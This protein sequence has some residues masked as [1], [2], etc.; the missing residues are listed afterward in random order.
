M[1]VGKCYNNYMTEKEKFIIN[2][3]TTFLAAKAAQEYTYCCMT[4]NHV[5]LVETAPI[6]DAFFIANEI[7]QN[8]TFKEE[9]KKLLNGL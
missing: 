6:E 7:W 4:D 2:Y 3:A 5:N 1:K 9:Y 8:E